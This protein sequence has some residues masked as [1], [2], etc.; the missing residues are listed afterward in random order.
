[1]YFWFGIWSILLQLGSAEGG[2]SGIRMPFLGHFA[3]C[4]LSAF[5]NQF[6]IILNHF[7]DDSLN[8]F[9]PFKFRLFYP[10]LLM[11]VLFAGGKKMTN[12]MRGKV[13][14][15]PLLIKDLGVSC[16]NTFK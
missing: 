3:V 11:P 13:G 5:R 2:E 7:L 4:C 1:M 6:G 16:G 15:L 9:T 12:D 8:P 10:L 14:V